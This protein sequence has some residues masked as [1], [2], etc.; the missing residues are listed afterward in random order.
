[1]ITLKSTARLDPARRDE[2]QCSLSRAHELSCWRAGWL[3]IVF[4]SG[5]PGL[6]KFSTSG[7]VCRSEAELLDQKS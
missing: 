4:T 2:K 6:V 3:L 1:M 7:P 5:R